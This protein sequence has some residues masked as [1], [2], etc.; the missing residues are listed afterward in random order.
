M[1]G[2]LRLAE[3]MARGE[4]LR[5]RMAESTRQMEGLFEFMLAEVFYG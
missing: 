1:R 3:V 4:S 2:A 5:G